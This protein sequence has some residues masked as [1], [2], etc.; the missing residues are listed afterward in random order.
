MALIA[1]FDHRGWETVDD[2]DSYYMD[3]F[4]GSLLFKN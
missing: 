3:E 4:K 1:L 2:R